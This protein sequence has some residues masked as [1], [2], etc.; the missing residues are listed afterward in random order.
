MLLRER[1]AKVPIFAKNCQI[2]ITNQCYMKILKKTVFFLSMGFLTVQLNAQSEKLLDAVAQETCD[3]IKDKDV[4]KMTTEELQV[5][6]GICMM[7]SLGT[8]Q[9]EMGGSLDLT[10]QA[11]MQAFGEKVGVRMVAKCPEQMMK[12]VSSTTATDKGADNI[13]TVEG[14]FKQVEGT[15]LTYIILEEADG[16]QQRLLWLRP[17]EGEELLKGNPGALKGKKVVIEYTPIECYSSQAKKYVTRKE[18][19]SLKPAN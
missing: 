8:H 6:L 5:E 13:A 15:E 16:S 4:S 19:V 9:K 7:G 14:S 11:S 1:R 12:V 10:N 17:F 3:C 18:I 2:L